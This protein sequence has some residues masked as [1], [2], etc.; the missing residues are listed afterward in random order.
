MNP[1]AR[2]R[3]PAMPRIGVYRD[4]HAVTPAPFLSPPLLRAPEDGSARTSSAGECA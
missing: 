2:H 4:M 3:R 1:L